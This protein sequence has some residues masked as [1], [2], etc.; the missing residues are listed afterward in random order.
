MGLMCVAA[1]PTKANDIGALGAA[2]EEI[3]IS[4]LKMPEN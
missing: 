4:E 3:E 1:G 2:E